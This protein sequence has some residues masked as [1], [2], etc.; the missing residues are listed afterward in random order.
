MRPKVLANVV[1]SMLYE[2]RFGPYFVEPV[3]CGTLSLSLSLSSPQFII[4]LSPPP[5][6]FSLDDS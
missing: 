2:K 6:S 4:F 3:V 5:P 1:S